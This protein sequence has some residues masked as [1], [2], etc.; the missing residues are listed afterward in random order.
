VAIGLELQNVAAELKE[1]RK[2]REK[3]RGL[4]EKSEIEKNELMNRINAIGQK[5][6]EVKSKSMEELMQYSKELNYRIQ[7]LEK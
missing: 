1:E 7:D 2:Q 4:L 6:P 3:L 5:D